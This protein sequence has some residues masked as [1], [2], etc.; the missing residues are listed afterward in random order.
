MGAGGPG[1]KI[2]IGASM[3]VVG[4]DV[5]MGGSKVWVAVLVGNAA[6]VEHAVSR[7]TSKNSRKECL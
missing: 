7:N 1:V 4:V 5:E 3:V 2:S 6:A